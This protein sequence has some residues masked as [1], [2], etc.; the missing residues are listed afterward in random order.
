MRLFTWLLNHL[1]PGGKSLREKI[2]ETKKTVFAFWGLDKYLPQFSPE[3]LFLAEKE[4]NS[5]LNVKIWNL[6]QERYENENNNILCEPKDLKKPETRAEGWKTMRVEIR[7]YD[8]IPSGLFTCIPALSGNKMTETLDCISAIFPKPTTNI[9]TFLHYNWKSLFPNLEIGL[10]Y[11]YNKN[12]TR[13][14]TFVQLSGNRIHT[15][16]ATKA[17]AHQVET[18]FQISYTLF[19]LLYYF[20]NLQKI[21]V[22]V[23]PGGPSLAQK[24]VIFVYKDPLVCR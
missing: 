5:G 19:K 13:Q 17:L 16:P 6:R 15:F 8:G 24:V 18:S 7:N 3:D 11:D 10:K 23:N 14:F 21:N 22:G 4:D 12:L 20:L 2:A 1:T 9:T